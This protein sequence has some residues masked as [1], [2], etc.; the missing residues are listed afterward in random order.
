[1]ATNEQL[2]VDSP[3]SNFDAS[4]DQDS[5]GQEPVLAG[6]DSTQSNVANILQ[7]LLHARTMRRSELRGNN[8]QSAKEAFGHGRTRRAM[9]AAASDARPQRQVFALN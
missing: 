9:K 3:V 6:L 2:S 4:D 8:Q 5:N 1:M 7:G